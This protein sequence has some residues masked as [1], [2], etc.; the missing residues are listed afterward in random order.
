MSNTTTNRP[1][2]RLYTVSGDG[3]NA[4][5]T[6]IGVAWKSRD[7]AGFTL[8]LNALPLDG[9]IVMREAKSKEEEAAA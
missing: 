8:S 4:R 5:W 1:H 7:G 6:D 3:K 2:F 9:R